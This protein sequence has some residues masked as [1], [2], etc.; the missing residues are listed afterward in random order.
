MHVPVAQIPNLF[1]VRMV[2]GP[3]CCEAI[4]ADKWHIKATDGRQ[5]KVRT[6]SARSFEAGGKAG[7][8]QEPK[9]SKQCQS[10]CIATAS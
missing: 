3:V 7:Q 8:Q 10:L 9:E 1:T 5:V 4:Q 6:L 2:R